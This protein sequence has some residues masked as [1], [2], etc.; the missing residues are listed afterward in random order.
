MFEKGQVLDNKYEIIGHIGTGGGG[1]VYKATQ[2]GLNRTV[3]IKQIKES[4]VGV[5]KDRGEADILK[6]LKNNYIPSVFDFIENGG[7][8]YTVMEFVDG[9]S[10]QQLI[11]SGKRFPRKKLLKYAR[12]LCEAV[13]Y[14]HSRKPPVIHS[15]IKPANIMLTPEDNICLIDYNISLIIDGNENAVG[16]SDG[17]SPPEQYGKTVDDAN[18]EKSAIKSD[19]TAANDE[20]LIDRTEFTDLTGTKTLID[21]TAVISAA[22]GET[23]LESGGEN[24]YTKTMI[25]RTDIAGGEAFT[26]PEFENS[27]KLTGGKN[28]VGINRRIDK[29]SDIYSIGASVYGIAL[30]ER[31]A[32]STGK[33]ELLKNKNSNL[34]ESFAAIIDKAMEKNPAKRFASAEQML[35]ALNNIR[36][37][38]KRYKNMVIRQEIAAFSVIAAMAVSCLIAVLGYMRLGDEDIAQYDILVS[39]M[40]NA[41]ISEAEKY[42]NEAAEIFP[43]RAEAYEKMAMLIYESGNYLSA[44]EYIEN[45][46]ALESLYIGEGGEKYSFGK[47]YYILGRCYMETNENALSAEALGKAVAADSDEISY[48]CDYASAL[49]RC[50]EIEKSEK[51]LETAV[52]KGISDADILF[53]K[54]EIEFNRKNYAECIENIKRC[55]EKVPDSEYIYRAYM[56][57]ANA[58]SSEYMNVPEIGAERIEF[59]HGAVKALPEE[60]TLPFYEMLAQAYIDE[61]ERS[62]NDF[63]FS[64]ALK[65]YNE[66]DSKGWGTVSSN[67]TTIIKLYRKIGNFEY[68]KEYA[69]KM[70]E[71]N[72]EDYEIYKL[73]AFIES[74]L[75]NLKDNSERDYSDFCAYYEKA[76]ALCDNDEDAEMQLLAEAYKNAKERKN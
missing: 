22:D 2:I 31:P 57:G 25:D 62:Q 52:N 68:A 44:A 21:S 27:S 39:Q 38:D 67:Y 13:S 1:I 8:V 55:I 26:A 23:V 74:D 33:V 71:R 51:I 50:G 70:L 58:Y 53:V 32:V 5:L 66:M 59:L 20:T 49:A 34:S 65:I 47:L 36:R 30:G 37:Y 3:A 40:D 6:N 69:E 14:L 75:Q 54:G 42:C 43:D 9:Q 60:K 76:A 41:D 16:V 61:A 45:V 11:D 72:G 15:D 48:Y 73:L 4:V 24:G 7:E 64:E 46:I 56:L 63:Y 19:I 10:F 28:S 17:Y 29:R 12:Q 18:Y 35:K